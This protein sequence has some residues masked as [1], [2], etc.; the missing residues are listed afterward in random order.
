MFCE[1]QIALY[2]ANSAMTTSAQG[3][4]FLLF[5]GCGLA[6]ASKRST[7]NSMSERWINESTKS[8]ANLK[9]A[10][11]KRTRTFRGCWGM[12]R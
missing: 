11:A 9:S 1:Y 5:S 3:S 2:E 6:F 4:S 12:L 10:P 8:P 7:R